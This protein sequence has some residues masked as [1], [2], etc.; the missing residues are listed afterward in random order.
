MTH[1]TPRSVHT[2]LKSELPVVASVSG[3]SPGAPRVSPIASAP[4]RAV[5]SRTLAAALFPGARAVGQHPWLLAAG[6]RVEIIGVPSH[7]H[8]RPDLSLPRHPRARRAVGVAVD[9]SDMRRAGQQD[10]FA[11]RYRT[12]TRCR[13]DVTKKN[14]S[15]P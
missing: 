6:G 15:A 4:A 14:S 8:P 12:E 3:A 11:R 10:D 13:R 1:G 7:I 9:V 2:R 5:I